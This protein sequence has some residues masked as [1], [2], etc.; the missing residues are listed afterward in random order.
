VAS[1]LTL[2]LIEKCKETRGEIRK[3]QFYV[4]NAM[5]YPFSLFGTVFAGKALAN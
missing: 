1:I 2:G 4:Q 3:L 5:T